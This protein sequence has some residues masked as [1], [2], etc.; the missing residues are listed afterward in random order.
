MV[1]KPFSLSASH[2]LHSQYL[3]CH[4]P[5]GRTGKDKVSKVKDKVNKNF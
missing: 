1:N 4:N 5:G 3:Q 2:L